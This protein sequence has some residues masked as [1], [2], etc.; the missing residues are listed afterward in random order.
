MISRIILVASIA[1]VFYVVL[2]ILF[3]RLLQKR[4]NAI[5]HRIVT[6]S[7]FSGTVHGT[8]NESLLI[9]TEKEII[10]LEPKKTQYYTVSL[11]ERLL[12]LRWQD[13]VGIK[14]GGTVMIYLPDAKHK[15]TLC[16]FHEERNPAAYTARIQKADPSVKNI[17]KHYCTATGAMLEFLVFLN[18]LNYPQM[19]A[20]SILALF[21]IF[22][23]ALPYCPPGLLFTFLGRHLSTRSASNKKRSRQLSTVGIVIYTAGILVNIAVLFFIIS[24]VG[25][26][27]SFF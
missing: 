8:L 23:K 26:G 1:V 21:G 18:T 14:M 15:K 17:A 13:V 12:P 24:S 16:V 2:P 22:G 25:F 19:T 10:S 3:S 5:V 7:H 11:E 27:G 6:L 4:A 20:V 9:Q